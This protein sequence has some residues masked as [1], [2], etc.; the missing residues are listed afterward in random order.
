MFKKF[1][2]IKNSY[3]K[4]NINAWE[5]RFPGLLEDE[6]V[7]T[8]KLDGANFQVMFDSEGKRSYASR[9]QTLGL[10]ANFFDWQHCV[11]R[12][13]E[14]YWDKL[15]E[16]VKSKEDIET[17]HVYGELFGEGVQKRINYGPGKK[18]LPFSVKMNGVTLTHC[19]ARALLAYADLPFTWWAPILGV[20][21]GLAAAMKFEVE[22][23][24]SR[25]AGDDKKGN[26]NIEGVVVE[27][28]D[29]TYTFNSD[30]EGESVF[31]LKI[32][33]EKFCDAMKVKH[34]KSANLEEFKGGESWERLKESFTGMFNENRLAD[35]F[36]KEGPIQ[37]VKEIGK[38]I[39]LLTQDV[40][41][42][43]LAQHED[44]IISLTDA[45]RKNIF[46]SAAKL[47][48]PMLKEALSE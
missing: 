47:A 38:Y 31:R 19:H 11:L 5:R 7:L 3:D 41:E 14:E 44:D 2:K 24:I 46:S 34:K 39:K 45:E 10:E 35:L 6:F 25:E 36:G 33:S 18:F 13:Y 15:S 20:V 48:V 37:D 26:C 42:D 21:K 8:E 16:F 28:L 1:S 27:A 4:K 30:D 22:D 32:K 9:N 17:L 12:Q 40:R 29:S 43:F 23:V